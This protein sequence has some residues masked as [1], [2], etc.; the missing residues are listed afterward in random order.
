MEDLGLV[1][2]DL[3]V[4]KAGVLPYVTLAAGLVVVLA[5]NIIFQLPA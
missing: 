3:G 2:Q 5:A 4:K 1:G